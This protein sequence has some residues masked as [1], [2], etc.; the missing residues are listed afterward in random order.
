[1]LPNH[2]ITT[3]LVSIAPLL[4]QAT[5]TLP[6]KT[7]PQYFNELPQHIMQQ[8]TL[9]Q[10]SKTLPFNTP[11]D[12]FKALPAEIIASLQNPADELAGIAPVL[13]GLPKK[14]PYT[15]PK[16]YLKQ[17][18]AIPQK[19]KILSI[20]HWARYA[21][22]AAILGILVTTGIWIS[23]AKKA[24]SYAAYTQLNPQQELSKLSDEDLLKAFKDNTLGI[25]TSPEPILEQE[26]DLQYFLDALSDE[27]LEDQWQN[28]PLTNTQSGI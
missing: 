2:S 4:A 8:I 25:I 3:E 16:G 12:Y 9:Q 13:A 18:I 24:A 23:S 14:H 7:P 15:Q 17:P 26:I 10:L 5:K 21:V 27:E 28:L 19:A 20:G 1:M 11:S 22:A 6:Y